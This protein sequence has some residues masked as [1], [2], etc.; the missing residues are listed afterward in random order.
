MTPQPARLVVGVTSASAP[1][2]G[3]ALLRALRE[4]ESVDSH[5]VVSREAELTIG[6]EMGMDLHEFAAPADVVYEPKDL[7]SAVSSGSY[8]TM[9][10]VV[11]PCSMRTLAAIATGNSTDLISRAAQATAAP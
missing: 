2:L 11:M 3:L 6:H 1:Q 7:G 5:L 10:M 8:L 4:L 9:G